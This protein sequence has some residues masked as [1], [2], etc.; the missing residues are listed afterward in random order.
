[1]TRHGDDASMIHRESESRAL[2]FASA[3]ETPAVAFASSARSLRL[4]P[5]VVA[6][7]ARVR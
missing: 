1:M 2:F 3:S 7:H 5:R 6:S 4:T